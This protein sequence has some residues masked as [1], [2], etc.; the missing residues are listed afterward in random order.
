MPGKPS[1]QEAYIGNQACARC[2]SAIY[3]PYQRTPM[4]HARGMAGEYV[5][6]ADF[7]HKKSGVH[8]RIYKEGRKSL[9]EL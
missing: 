4:A 8:Y 5:I 3:E 1:E 6:P 9:A 7:T 2:H